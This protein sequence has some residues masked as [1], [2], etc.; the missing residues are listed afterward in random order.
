[1]NWLD[2]LLMLAAWAAVIFIWIPP[3]MSTLNLASLDCVP[4]EN[5]I[6]GNTAE[7]DPIFAALRAQLLELGFES[8]GQMQQ[9][10]QFF[11]PHWRWTVEHHVFTSRKLPVF[12]TIYRSSRWE[13]YKVSFS[14]FFADGMM[15]WTSSSGITSVE[16]PD[17]EILTLKSYEMKTVLDYHQVGIER[18]QKEH[19]TVGGPRDLHECIEVQKGTD[20]V[21]VRMGAIRSVGVLYLVV[22]SVV[23]GVISLCLVGTLKPAVVTLRFI[24]LTVLAACCGCLI[25]EIVLR[26][27]M[28]QGPWAEKG[29]V[30]KH[31]ARG[32]PLFKFVNYETES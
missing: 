32:E 17:M 26:W 29:R 9:V 16:Y 5:L 2:V 4:E 11:G 23:S 6:G 31:L 18:L 12:A 15:L 8:A 1:M 28:V 7:D 3:I 20:R 13:P 14:S 19:G 30:L 24:S 25:A 27:M 22:N 10:A 21:A